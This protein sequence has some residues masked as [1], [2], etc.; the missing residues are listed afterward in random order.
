MLKSLVG[1]VLVVSWIYVPH[2]AI[3]FTLLILTQSYNIT[4]ILVTS[5]HWVKWLV[6]G[7]QT[8]I[9]I[10]TYPATSSFT[11]ESNLIQLH[12]TLTL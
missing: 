3:L 6:G 11:S 9:T 7:D 5:S 12:F 2:Q 4:D 1:V 10:S 8:A